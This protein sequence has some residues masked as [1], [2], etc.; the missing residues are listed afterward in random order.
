MTS[1]PTATNDDSIRDLVNLLLDRAVMV[2]HAL[3]RLHAF[4]EIHP[5]GDPGAHADV[6]QAIA[7]MTG[8]RAR[9]IHNANHLTRLLG[10]PPVRR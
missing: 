2:T 8:V 7:A 3:H 1:D 5:D 9:L 4:T 6:E 10:T